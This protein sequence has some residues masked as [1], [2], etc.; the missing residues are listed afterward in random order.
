MRRQH[1]QPASPHAP[2]ASAE[3]WHPHT[4]PLNL[5]CE[6]YFER[7][8][9]CFGGCWVLRSRSVSWIS[10][11]LNLYLLLNA[12][13]ALHRVFVVPAEWSS[14]AC[15]DAGLDRANELVL[16]LIWD[17]LQP[18]PAGERQGH[19]QGTSTHAVHCPHLAPL[20]SAHC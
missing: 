19:T 8:R 2:P 4:K 17:H 3:A 20:P 13:R 15:R 1:W 14:Q 18:E 9:S 11:L 6:D 7:R 5:R 10:T 16:E 12:V